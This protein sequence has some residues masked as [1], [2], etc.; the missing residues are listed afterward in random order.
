[1]HSWSIGL[2]VPLLFSIS[3]H[4]TATRHKTARLHSMYLI[5]VYPE[6][7]I[8]YTETDIMLKRFNTEKILTTRNVYFC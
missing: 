6:Q 8:N 4:M 1:M 2:L 5:F 7:F 3:H